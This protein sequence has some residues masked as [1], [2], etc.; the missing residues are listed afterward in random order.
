MKSL[1][2]YRRSALPWLR[3]LLRLRSAKIETAGDRSRE[4]YRRAAMTAAAV[5]FSKI[6]SMATSI[7]TV[8]LTFRYLGAERYGMW[9]TITS[10]VMMMSFADLGIGNGLIN[11]VADALG[12]KDSRAARKASASA[13]WVLSAIAVLFALGMAAAYPFINTSRL[14]NLSSPL[15]MREAGP[16]LL[17]FFYCFVLNLPMCAIRN[18]QTGMQNGFVNNL[19]D[20]LGSIAS[21]VALL[22]AIHAHGGLPLL[23]LSLAAP[24]VIVSMLNGL[25][26]FGWSHP[27]LLPSPTAFSPESASRLFH[28]GMMFF[29]L[30][31][32]ISVGMQTDNIVIAQILGAKSVAAYAVPARLF[33]M[34]NAFLIL[35]SGAMWPAYADAVAHSDGPWIRRGFTR[36]AVGGTALTIVA[37]VF[38]AIFGNQILAVW[39]GPQ[40]HAPPALLAVFGLQC[41]LYA[42]LQPM[43]F[44]L[45]AVGQL[46]VQVIGA[47]VMA[48]LNLA[49]SILFVIHY[50]IIGAVLGTVISVLVAQVVP[51]TVVTRNVLKKFSQSTIEPHSESVDTIN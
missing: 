27:E 4:R 8:R 13:F 45:N 16:A 12:R 36:V 19:W 23:V 51:L 7:L 48:V 42:Y 20:S 9:M 31:L 43:N 3:S 28:T 46:R 11:I 38:L 29:L 15:A 25:E 21:L 30:Q 33:S 40:M 10:V 6:V 49:L 34:V 50:G 2:S 37:A 24:P 47:L 5:S 39:V 41:V 32:A 26:L 18:I 17:V 35:L 14:F 44:L 1:A 22:L